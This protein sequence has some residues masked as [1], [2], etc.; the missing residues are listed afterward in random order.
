MQRKMIIFE[1]MRKFVKINISKLKVW[2]YTYTT[3]L[4][5]HLLQRITMIS[6]SIYKE[7]WIQ[8]RQVGSSDFDRPYMIPLEILKSKTTNLFILLLYSL[9]LFLVGYL[10]NK[11]HHFK[12]TES[13]D[14]KMPLPSFEHFSMSYLR[15][16]SFVASVHPLYVSYQCWSN[17]L[18][19]H[20][21]K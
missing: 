20:L 6:R 1:T 12:D 11:Y 9:A 3:I 21:S 13:I 19:N 18:G 15:S 17:I 8:V 7:S 4:Y 10:T 14:R 16:S 2:Y 5:N